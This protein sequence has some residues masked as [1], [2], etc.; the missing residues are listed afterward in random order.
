M[1]P[2]LTGCIHLEQSNCS[3]LKCV[4]DKRILQSNEKLLCQ[5]SKLKKSIQSVKLNGYRFHY[6]NVKG[7]FRLSRHMQPLP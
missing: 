7:H 5:W 2:L 4:N 6:K 3:N 1:I